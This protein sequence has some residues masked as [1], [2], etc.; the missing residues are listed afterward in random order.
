V[1]GF[2]FSPLKVLEYM[3]AGICPVAS[4]VGEI[5]AL[6][7]RGSRGVLLEPGSV[8][9]LAAALVE[10]AGDRERARRLGARA[11]DYVL[12]HHRWRDNAERVLASLGA[13]AGVAV[14]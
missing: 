11:R 8:D 1:P 3:A 7:G 2:Y 14:A 4:D 6:L 13:T 5:G 10:L 9:A 12:A